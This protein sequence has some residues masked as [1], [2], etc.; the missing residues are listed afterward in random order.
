MT[1]SVQTALIA[2]IVP[3]ITAIGVIIVAMR[4][5]ATAKKIDE[6]ADVVKQLDIKVDGRLTQLLEVSLPAEFAKGKL[7]GLA[8]QKAEAAIIAMGELTKKPADS[9][10]VPVSVIIEN[11]KPVPVVV[12]KLK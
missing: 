12:E 10:P 5:A 4:Q 6:N 9:S 3:A 11:P 1:E 2:S 7:A 8:E